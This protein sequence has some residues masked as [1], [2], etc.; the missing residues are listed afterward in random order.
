M[1]KGGTVPLGV[2]FNT[3]HMW[4]HVSFVPRPYKLAHQRWIKAAHQ[5]VTVL[6]DELIADTL[7]GILDA[8]ARFHSLVSKKTGLVIVGVG[9][10]RPQ[11]Q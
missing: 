8:Y 11:L 7:S 1:K 10:H 3:A 5:C 9:G 2:L 4:R 6:L